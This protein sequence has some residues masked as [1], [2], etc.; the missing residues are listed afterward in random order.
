MTEAFKSFT[1]AVFWFLMA[2]AALCLLLHVLSGFVER[3]LEFI[4]ELRNR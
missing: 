4:D 2:T 3:S 1:I